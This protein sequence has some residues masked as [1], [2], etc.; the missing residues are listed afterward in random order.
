M[1]FTSRTGIGTNVVLTL[2]AVPELASAV[3]TSR[4]H[5]FHFT[6]HEVELMAAERNALSRRRRKEDLR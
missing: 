6:M 3:Q 1:Q 5:S 2:P 4:R